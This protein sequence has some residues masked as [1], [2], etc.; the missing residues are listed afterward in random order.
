MYSI[1]HIVLNGGEQR[2]IAT[3]TYEHTLKEEKM[4]QSSWWAESFSCVHAWKLCAKL[5]KV[6][7]ELEGGVRGQRWGGMD[8]G[9]GL[10]SWNRFQLE[11]KV[12]TSRNSWSLFWMFV[13]S[14]LDGHVCV[15]QERVLLVL[16]DL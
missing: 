15:W 16:S 6:S 2:H 5:W 1:E 8:G 13:V 14:K 3:V 11:A 10:S 12:R 9:A 7:T 4:K